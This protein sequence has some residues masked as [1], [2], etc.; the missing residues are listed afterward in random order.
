MAGNISGNG[1]EMVSQL[2]RNRNGTLK[3]SQ[4]RLV[5]LRTRRH[6]H[7]GVS[8]KGPAIEFSLQVIDYI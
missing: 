2:F 1:S 8:A 4:L 3:K 7:L 6:P 5:S